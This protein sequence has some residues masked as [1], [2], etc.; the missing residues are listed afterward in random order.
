MLGVGPGEFGRAYRLYRDPTYVD[1]RLG[2]AHNF[3]LN[4]LAETGIVGA[5]VGAGARRALLLRAWWRLWRSADTPARRLHLEGALAALVGFGAQSFFDT[6]T[7]APLVLLALGLAAYCVTA[8]RS[9]SRSAAARQPPG[10]PRQPD[11]G[12]RLR[13]GAAPLG[14]GTGGVQR[15]RDRAARWNRRSRRR[16]STRRCICTT[17][18]SPT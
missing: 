3:Y 5:L 12:G 13:R 4:T 9:R 14:S 7:I 16:R 1:N 15:Q 10:S 2:T 11:P 8:T 6:F 18:K 17:C